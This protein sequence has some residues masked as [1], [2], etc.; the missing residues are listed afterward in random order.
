MVE[1]N[2]SSEHLACRSNTGIQR[3]QQTNPVHVLTLRLPHAS[4]RFAGA[5]L[6]ICERKDVFFF[7]P[8][9]Q[10]EGCGSKFH[11]ADPCP[12][13]PTRSATGWEARTFEQQQRYL[14]LERR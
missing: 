12:T 5:L 1:M 3:Q 11:T 2:M 14:R 7:D 13:K 4:N 6:S 9:V 8:V 10:G